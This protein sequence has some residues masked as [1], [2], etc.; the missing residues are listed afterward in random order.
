MTNYPRL[1]LTGLG[2]LAGFLGATLLRSC[3]LV[4][5]VTFAAKFMGWI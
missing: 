2:D 1:I 3:S 4:F 5:V